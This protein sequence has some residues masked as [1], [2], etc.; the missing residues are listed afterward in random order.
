MSPRQSAMYW[1]EWARLRDM[2][3]ARGHTV[4][5]VEEYRHN[6]TRRALGVLKSSKDFTNAD[7][8]RVLARLK[9]ESD[10]ANLDAQLSLQDS[11][12]R[13]RAYLL[14]RLSECCAELFTVGGDER[15]R[16]PAAREG[17]IRGTARNVCKHELEQ[18]T[19]AD[20]GKVLGCLEA[21]LRRLVA[22]L[23]PASLAENPF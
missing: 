7:F 13:R 8:D 22:K 4:A 10:P 20:L 5:Q 21:R 16:E 3:R 18:C 9:A 15:L 17:Y 11:P 19:D 23:P 14:H 2:L 6:L 12:D 1:A